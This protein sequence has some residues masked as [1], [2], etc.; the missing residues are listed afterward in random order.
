M[1][2]KVHTDMYMH[3]LGLLNTTAPVHP[4]VARRTLQQVKNILKC[5]PLARFGRFRDR[6]CRLNVE[7]DQLREFWVLHF[8]Q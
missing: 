3:N 4:H 6:Y 1:Q 2:D 5:A 8:R 7:I